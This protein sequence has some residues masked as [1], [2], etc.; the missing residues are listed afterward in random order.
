[1]LSQ[2]K[3]E[4]DVHAI[5]QELTSS[6]SNGKATF[7]FSRWTTKDFVAAIHKSLLD[8]ESTQRWKL[9]DEKYESNWNLSAIGIIGLI[10]VIG[11]GRG[12][13]DFAWID[14]NAFA[15]ALSGL[16]ACTWFVL[17]SLERAAL[18]TALSKFMSVRIT[19]GFLFAAGI[20]VATSD[21]NTALNAVLGV[22]ASNA[23]L[24]R[25]FLVAALFLKLLWPAFVVLG[26]LAGINLLVVFAYARWRTVADDRNSEY[27]EFPTMA[28]IFVVSALVVSGIYVM[29]MRRAFSEENIPEK[30][31]RLALQLD[32]NE[33]AYCLQRSSNHRYL[34]IGTNQDKVLIAPL[35]MGELSLKS[36]AT[37]N[38]NRIDDA[39][40]VVRVVSCVPQP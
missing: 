3:I 14:Q 21:A 23:P 38:V 8:K 36:F 32:F 1:M 5:K 22:D 35:P 7:A 9:R 13:S 16:I 34:F 11:P 17:M 2:E 33:A 6:S 30:A 39:P 4:N 24:A 31:Y 19:V 12:S 27:R 10:L 25:A 20:T 18:F 37:A 15:F 28:L 40:Y 29:T 26:I